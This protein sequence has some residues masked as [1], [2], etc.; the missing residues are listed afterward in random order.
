MF[1]NYEELIQNNSKDIIK[2]FR[3]Y[4]TVIFKTLFSVDVKYKRN[5][6][7]SWLFYQKLFFHDIQHVFRVI[8]HLHLEIL[9][10]CFLVLKDA[11][12]IIIW[13]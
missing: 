7:G 4:I 1:K 10:M 9:V 3:V 8:C 5:N 12:I 11:I 2:C 13:F 6:I